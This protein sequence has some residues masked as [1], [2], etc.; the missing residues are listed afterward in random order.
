MPHCCR[1]SD[2]AIQDSPTLWRINIDVPLPPVM[3]DFR[4]IFKAT[5]PGCTVQ[6]SSRNHLGLWQFVFQLPKRGIK[7]EILESYLRI[8]QWTVTTSDHAN[9]SH[10]LFLHTI[11]HPVIDPYEAE[12]RRTKMGELVNRAKSYSPYTGSKPAASDLFDHVQ[13]LIA[14]HPRYQVVDVIIPAPPGNPSK[15]FDL[16]LFIAE[17]L[18]EHLGIPIYSCQKTGNMQQQKAVEQDLSVLQTNVLGKFSVNQ[19]LNGKA[20][21]VLDDLYQSGATINEVVRACR[22]AG[23][24][25]VLSLVATKTAKF[26]NGLTASDW[27][28]VSMEAEDGLGS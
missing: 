27:Y 15:A 11:P 6:S 10:A 9:E 22:A 5:F 25:T 7:K 8:L 4:H 19:N 18:A 1:I 14:R 12:F 23:A 17:K 28:G 21:L 26:C 2:F 24:Q 13:Y 3:V 16:P 20:V